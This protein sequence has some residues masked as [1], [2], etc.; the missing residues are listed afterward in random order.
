[1]SQVQIIIRVDGHEY[2]TKPTDH[3]NPI[4]GVLTGIHRG[5][6]RIWEMKAS[7]KLAMRHPV[8]PCA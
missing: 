4:Q 1:M 7:Y 6:C 8:I 2:R 3:P 5:T